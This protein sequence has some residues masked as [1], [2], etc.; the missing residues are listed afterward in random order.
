MTGEIVSIEFEIMAY[1]SKKMK[2]V[3]MNAVLYYYPIVVLRIFL[4]LS[5]LLKLYR[6]FLV[7]NQ[8]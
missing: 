3:W 7:K 1:T 5:C 4:F 2:W 8:G 6:V